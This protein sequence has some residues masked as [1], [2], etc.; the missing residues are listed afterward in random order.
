[1]NNLN[2][3]GVVTKVLVEQGVA[4]A[5]TI[6]TKT[7]ELEVEYQEKFGEICV[8][9]FIIASGFLKNITRKIEGYRSSIELSLLE[10]FLEEVEVIHNG[11]LTL[12]QKKIAEVV[13]AVVADAE[14]KTEE[15]MT[16]TSETSDEKS[17]KVEENS[18]Q[19]VADDVA[20][21]EENDGE[22]SEENDADDAKKSDKIDD[23]FDEYA[24]DLPVDDEM[25]E[26]AAADFEKEDNTPTDEDMAFFEKGF[27]PIVGH[28]SSLDYNPNETDTYKMNPF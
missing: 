13:P 25:L 20:S 12:S 22:T 14:S 9:D 4:R 23:D 7:G 1:M 18:S 10:I 21:L 6:D 27:K 26:T 5:I 19:V 11:T 17:V 28:Q 24:E 3:S 2:I 8:G 15:V 16:K